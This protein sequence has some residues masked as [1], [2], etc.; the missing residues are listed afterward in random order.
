MGITFDGFMKAIKGT[1]R[2]IEAIPAN[3]Q[4]LSKRMDYLISFKQNFESNIENLEEESE[5]KIESVMDDG[6]KIVDKITEIEKVYQAYKGKKA[7]FVQLCCVVKGVPYSPE[8][9]PQKDLKSESRLGSESKI[10][11]QSKVQS[12]SIKQPKVEVSS[13][14]KKQEEQLFKSE[15]KPKVD[16]PI[17]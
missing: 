12:S 16:S 2:Q 10:V 9:E 6:F 7:T 14:P 11:P 1:K 3:E 5:S 15:F 13:P 17:K 8:M 4:D